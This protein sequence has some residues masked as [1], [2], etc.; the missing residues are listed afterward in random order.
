MPALK[1]ESRVSGA[2]FIVCTLTGWAS[3]LLFLKH[4]APFIDAWTANGWRY[5]LSA[6]L[7]LPL[8]VIGSLRGTLPTRL[9][10]RAFV[11]AAFNCIG[12]VFFA[13]IPYYIG[14]GLG[15][16]LLRSSIVFSTTGALILFEDERP[17]VRSP[18]FWIGLALVCAGSAGTVLFGHAPITGGT[19]VGITMAL[20]A[21]AFYGCYG[22]SVRY[23]M[24]GVPA[25]T[26]FAAI[27]LYTAIG[28]VALMIPFGSRGGLCALD[29]SAF[30]WFIL[31]LSSLIGIALGHIFYYAAIARLGVAISTA[32]VQLAPF[33]C[34]AG[35]FFLFGEVL[36]PWQWLFGFVMLLG[37][38]SLIV[39]D[40]VRHRQKSDRTPAFPVEIEDAGSP[41]TTS[42][43]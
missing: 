6:L 1:N 9:W 39:A 38:A 37:A 25:I 13:L 22:L 19:A 5:G 12:Q 10:R 32:I 24:H 43:A 2:V 21:G 17:L 36:T 4:L 28:M 29:L 20:T 42:S 23:F 31:A 15:G 16:F 7:L 3:V 11:P 33:L 26:S 30:N 14:P 34:A 18:G 27:S 40:K 41:A 8:L 35:S